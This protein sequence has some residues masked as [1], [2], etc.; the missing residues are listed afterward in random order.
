MARTPVTVQQAVVTG[1]TLTMTAAHVDGNSFANDGK[2]AIYVTNGSG[3]NLTVTIQAP[4][5]GKD[6]LV[7]TD[8]DVVVS[9]GTSELIGPFRKDVYDQSDGSVYLDWSTETSVTFAA[10][11]IG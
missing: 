9:T 4:D 3:G 8:R 5:S 6:G 2:T 11:R 1:A 10:I 7:V